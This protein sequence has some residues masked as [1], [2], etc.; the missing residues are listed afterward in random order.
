[1]NE[2]LLKEFR[3]QNSE[4]RKHHWA[5]PLACYRGRRTAQLREAEVEAGRI[6]LTPKTDLDRGI[7]ESLADFAAGRSFG[8]FRADKELINSLHR[9]SAKVGS[10]TK[11]RRKPRK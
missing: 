7:T 6:T 10:K 4:F 9:E 1:M 5:S 3:I 8:P 2:S 11:V